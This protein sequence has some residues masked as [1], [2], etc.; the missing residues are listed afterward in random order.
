MMLRCGART[1]ARTVQI[2]L[3]IAPSSSSMRCSPPPTTRL[4]SRLNTQPS[5][6][7][8]IEILKR[9]TSVAVW[10]TESP[11]NAGCEADSPV[12]D[13]TMLVEV[14]I[15]GRGKIVVDLPDPVVAELAVLPLESPVPKNTYKYLSPPL[16]PVLPEDVVLAIKGMTANG[17]KQ[18]VFN[19]PREWVGMEEV[20]KSMEAMENR[21]AGLVQGLE[22]RLAAQRTEDQQIWA[23]GRAED[24][25]GWAAQHIEDLRLLAAQRA[26][27]RSLLEAVVQPGTTWDFPSE[28]VA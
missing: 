23:A 22:A 16:R 24:Q 7:Q 20:Q 4:T 9:C 27:D 15:E 12:Q 5:S 10:D 19:E 21:L 28:G 26:E 2:S 1:G 18:F 25:Q 17:Y 8:Q 3:A 6:P 11:A 13:P 14:I